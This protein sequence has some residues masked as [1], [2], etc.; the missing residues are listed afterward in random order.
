MSLHFEWDRAKSKANAL[1]HDVTFNEAASVFYDERGLLVG[2]PDHSE[3]EDRFLLLGMSREV[4]LLVVA[5]CY[6]EASGAI[7]LISARRANRGEQRQYF[8]GKE[9]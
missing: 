1:K 5:H 6:R 7:R 9:R 8:K 2:D 3:Q 4:R